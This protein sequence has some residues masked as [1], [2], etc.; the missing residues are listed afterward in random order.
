MYVCMYVCMYVIVLSTAKPF[1]AETAGLALHCCFLASPLYPSH[2][3]SLLL[4]LLFLFV[5]LPV[6]LLVLCSLLLLVLCSWPVRLVMRGATVLIQGETMGSNEKNQ[7]V[8]GVGEGRNE[9]DPYP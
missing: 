2:L 1:L 6:L 3:P 8:V 5:F 7:D 9:A 4:L